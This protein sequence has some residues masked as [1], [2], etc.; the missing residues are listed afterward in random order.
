MDT[1]ETSQPI[2]QDTSAAPTWLARIEQIDSEL[3]ELEDERVELEQ[4]LLEANSPFSVGDIVT[5]NAGSQV[6]RGTVMSFSAFGGD[7]DDATL[8]CRRILKNGS[9]GE[10]CSVYHW[11]KPKTC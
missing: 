1:Q 6:R 9:E 8:R 5:W 10:V 11:D 4:K 2:E 7:Y 3:Q